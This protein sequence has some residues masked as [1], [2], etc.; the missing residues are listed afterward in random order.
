ME[1][2]RREKERIVI[3]RGSIKSILFLNNIPS[4]NHILILIPGLSIKSIENFSKPLK[5]KESH[6]MTDQPTTSSNAAEHNIFESQESF[7][8]TEEKEECKW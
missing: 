7:T 5:I 6:A 8:G 4:P 1:N 3:P 2:W